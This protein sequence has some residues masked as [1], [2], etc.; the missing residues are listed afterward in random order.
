MLYDEVKT[1][2]GLS[3]ALNKTFVNRN[4]ELQASFLEFFESLD[5]TILER[6]WGSVE[7]SDG[8]MTFATC[9]RKLALVLKGI[10]SILTKKKKR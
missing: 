10:E 4:T 9:K 7:L 8:K 3:T 5:L 1:R 6:S 2:A